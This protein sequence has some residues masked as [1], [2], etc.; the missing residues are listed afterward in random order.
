MLFSRD[1]LAAYVE[2]PADTRVVAERLT[3]AGFSVDK[4]SE[5][6]DGSGDA[7]L[8]VDVTTNRPDC[9][10]HLGLARELAVLFDR[11]LRMPEIRGAGDGGD[12]GIPDVEIADAAE[13][14]RFVG[15]VI[16]GIRVAPSPEW[17]VRRLESIGLRAI[18]NVVDVTN[19]VLWE[20]G[21]PMHAYDLDRLAG[22][23]IEVRRARGGER[24]V[25]LDGV[26]RELDPEML[27]IA[28]AAAPVGLAGVM[29]GRDSE[30]TAG[31]TRLFLEAAHFD[32]RLVRSAAKRLGLHTDASHRFERGADVEACRFAVDRAAKLLADVAGSDVRVASGVVDRRPAS[33]APPRQGRLDRARLDAFAG[34]EN[35]AADVERWM[36]GLGFGLTPLAGAEPDATAVGRPATVWTATVPSWRWFDFEPGPDGEVYEADLFEEVL[37]IFGLDRIPAALPALPGADGPRTDRQRL[38][39]RL[40]RFL[41][42]VGYAEAINFSFEDPRVAAGLPTLRPGLAP[43][44]LLNPLSERYSAMRQSLLGNLLESAR[45]NQ[46]RGAAS[47]RLFEVA[48]VYFPRPEATAGDL[49]P[50]EEEHVAL[51]CGGRLG[52]PWD[53]AADLDLFDLKG[54]VEALAAALGCH[55]EAR[56]AASGTLPGMRDG[57]SAEIF[58]TAG[59]LAGLFGCLADEE[60]Y[61]LFAC[62]LKLSALAADGAGSDPGGA[63]RTVDLPPR[64]PGIGADLTLTHPVAVSWRDLAAAVEAVRP[65]D[66]VAF[67]LAARYQGE[68]VPAGAV[69]TT[70]SFS[71][72][73]GDR[74]LTQDQVND[75][76]LAL[77]AELTRRFGWKGAGA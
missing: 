10:N 3:F 60:G 59:A 23:R 75:R 34:A 12:A 25:T 70:I 73:A 63:H 39:D 66:L 38:R 4:V 53:R 1:W 6:A 13:C 47:V 62:E 55:L 50:D 41:A 9:M 19:F 51:V 14:P 43:L 17:L 27:V 57:S 29:G 16:E 67:S 61:P 49:L 71:Y 74:S 37:R 40:R 44:M 2:L 64:V 68:G 52:T 72:N 46:R 45:F 48:A 28:D 42:G 7:V 36:V 32:R 22:P 24:L 76:Q 69:N 20:T 8:D 21:Q 31:T 77:A 26:E 18:N 56:P 58:D 65:A 11:P 30:V 33:L 35:A 15:R 54:V 5:A